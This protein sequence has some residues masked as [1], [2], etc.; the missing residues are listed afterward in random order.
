MQVN[1]ASL[2]VLRNEREKRVCVQPLQFCCAQNVD[3]HFYRR[4]LKQCAIAGLAVIFVFAKS[5]ELSERFAHVQGVVPN[6]EP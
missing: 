1:L 5:G 3:Q 4:L 6:G 2:H